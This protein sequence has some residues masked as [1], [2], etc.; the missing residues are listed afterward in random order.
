MNKILWD[1]FK[2]TGDVRYY[3]LLKKIEIGEEDA[4]KESKRNSF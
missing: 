4:S 2:T 3:V 1:L